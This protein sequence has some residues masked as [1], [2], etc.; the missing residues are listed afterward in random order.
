MDLTPRSVRWC[1]GRGLTGASNPLPTPKVDHLGSRMLAQPCPRLRPP[2]CARRHNARTVIWRCRRPLAQARAP[3]P[4]PAQ[5][6]RLALPCLALPGLARLGFP[7]LGPARLGPPAISLRSGHENSHTDL[8]GTLLQPR[9]RRGWPGNS[10]MAFP[11]SPRLCPALP[12]HS[13]LCPA[14]L[15]LAGYAQFSGAPVAFP[16]SAWLRGAPHWLASPG[17][18]RIG[19]DWTALASPSGISQPPLHSAFSSSLARGGTP[20]SLPLELASRPGHGSAGPCPALP[21]FDRLS[22]TSP[23]SARLPRLRPAGPCIA[24][25]GL[26]SL[27][28]TGRACP[29]GN[30]LCRGPQNPHPDPGGAT[31]AS[32]TLELASRGCPSLG[33]SICLCLFPSRE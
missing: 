21:G 26:G 6:A 23:A 12:G 33:L 29:S 30:S 8:R 27:A 4:R 3:C 25:L 18:A 17:L 15:G 11:G 14:F 1:G 32:L 20:V 5:A 7:W 31:P 19:M 22:L 28:R 24:R 13:Q 9:S 2:A 16:G 10:S